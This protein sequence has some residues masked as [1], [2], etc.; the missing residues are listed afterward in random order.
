MLFCRGFEFHECL[1]QMIPDSKFNI[2]F[3]ATVHIFHFCTPPYT[4]IYVFYICVMCFATNI[5]AFDRET[6]PYVGYN[7]IDK[8]ISLL[9]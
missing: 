8:Y 6:Y 2:Q 3:D 1:N 9:L 7:D 4:C 5:V